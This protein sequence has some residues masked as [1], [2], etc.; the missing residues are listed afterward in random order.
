MTT[1]TYVANSISAHVLDTFDLATEKM[2]TL[3]IHVVSRSDSSVSQMVITTDGITTAETQ[4]AVALSSGRPD[5]ITTS[6]NNYVGEIKCTPSVYPTTFTMVKTVTAANLYGEHTVSGKNIR[7]T[8]GVGIYFE[9]GANNMTIRLANNNFFGNSSSYVTANVLGP[10]TTGSE[11]Y[12]ANNLV[13]YSGSDLSS[14]GD[15]TVVTSSGQHR[16]NQYIELDVVSGQKYR[17]TAN[18]F[19]VASAVVQNGRIVSGD[20]P[21]ITVGTSIGSE[22]VAVREATL[23]EAQYDIDFTATT[24]KV[25]IGYGFGVV[26]AQLKY[27]SASVKQLTP[28]ATY[29]QS[30]GTFYFKWSSVAAGSNVAVMNSN[31]VYVDASNNVFINTVNCGAQQ[32]TNKLAYSYTSNTIIYSYNGAAAAQ[33]SGTYYPE[34]T[35]LDFKTIPSEFSYVPVRLSNTTLIELTNG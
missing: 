16:N 4:D 19:Y 31:R 5:E 8:E 21:A 1:T 14:N 3:D 34:V 9:G 10:K 18:A 22:N 17:V 15:Y 20:V 26:G 12:S 13:A 6:I 27:R 35:T 25:Y 2:I 23:N 32:T 7:H 24:N 28:F 33:Q 29:N 30:N 11:L